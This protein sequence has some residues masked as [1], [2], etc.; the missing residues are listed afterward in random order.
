MPCGAKL[1]SDKNAKLYLT[2]TPDNL[3]YPIHVYLSHF[4]HACIN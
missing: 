4:T 2:W 3:D 1:S